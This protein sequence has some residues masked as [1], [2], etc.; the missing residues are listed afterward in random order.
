MQA[1]TLDKLQREGRFAPEQVI[2]MAEMVDM[3]MAE[4]QF[5]TV[6]ILDARFAAV[7]VLFAAVDARFAAAEVRFTKI[8]ARID[9]LEARMNAK[10]EALEAKIARDLASLKTQLVVVIVVSST[11]VGP[12]GVKLL[13][14]LVSGHWTG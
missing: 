9:V 2:A 1:A 13:N 8:E 14:A 11:A 10:F 4:A 12:L 6:P 3:A 5:V 7:D